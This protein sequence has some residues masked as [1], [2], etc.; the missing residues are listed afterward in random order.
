M[1]SPSTSSEPSLARS[2][3]PRISD[4]VSLVLPL[5]L[6]ILD[7]LFSLPSVN[8][9]ETGHFY[10]KGLIMGL[11]EVLVNES[12]RN[13]ILQLTGHKAVVVIECLDKVNHYYHICSRSRCQ[14]F[15]AP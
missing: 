2:I 8:K 1:L 15:T 12:Q 3:C 6:E 4:Q 9:L 13:E 10:F 7:I 11:V 14:I 5:L